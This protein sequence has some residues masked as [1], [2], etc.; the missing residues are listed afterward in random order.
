VTPVATVLVVGTLGR[1]YVFPEPGDTLAAIAEREL[2]DE[3]GA[4]ALLASWN[5]H[6]A[7]RR[8][9]VGAPGE[10]LCTDVVY[11]EAPRP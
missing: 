3:A 7:V 5:L 1:R 2:P 4:A 10:L 9:L 6:L 11:V 8:S